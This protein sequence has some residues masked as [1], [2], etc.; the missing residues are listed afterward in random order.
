MDARVTSVFT[1]VFDALLERVGVRGLWWP[2]LR[3]L[4]LPPA[5]AR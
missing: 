1:R 5:I 2:Q 4:H 3:R